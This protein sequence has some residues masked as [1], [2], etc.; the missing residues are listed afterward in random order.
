MAEEL[1]ALFG[2]YGPLTDVYVPVDYYTRDP[3]GFAYVQYPLFRLTKSVLLLSSLVHVIDCL[4][5]FFLYQSLQWVDDGV[6]FQIKVGQLTKVSNNKKGKDLVKQKASQ[7]YRHS[8]SQCACCYETQQCPRTNLRTATKVQK[9]TQ[10]HQLCIFSAAD[11]LRFM[12]ISFS[13]QYQLLLPHNLC[14][15]NEFK[16]DDR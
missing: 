9:K 11:N 6:A 10:S 2:K 8:H 15:R 5:L 1:R 13:Y 14:N 4:F 16:R 3:R 7:L 12:K